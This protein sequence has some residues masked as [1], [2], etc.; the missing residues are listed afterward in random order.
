MDGSIF[1]DGLW[2]HILY[3]TREIRSRTQA[4][5]KLMSRTLEPV[6]PSAQK[7][8]SARLQAKDE[9]PG[10]MFG[11]VVKT[12][13]GRGQRNLSIGP[14]GRVKHTPRDQAFTKAV[15]MP[16]QYP[17]GMRFVQESSEDQSEDTGTSLEVSS[18]K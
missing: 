9:N 13:D 7:P 14:P 10:G 6:P 1:P 12:P 16:P 2:N 5:Q 15:Q 4:V 11:H 8:R 17:E 3:E 18:Q